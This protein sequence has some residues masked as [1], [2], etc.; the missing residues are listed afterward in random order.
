[1]EYFTEKRNNI[2]LQIIKPVFCNRCGKLMKVEKYG[3]AMTPEEWMRFN[4]AS[5][6]RIC[7]KCRLLRKKQ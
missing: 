2:S 4:K 7:W 6:K 5:V 3:D 1:M